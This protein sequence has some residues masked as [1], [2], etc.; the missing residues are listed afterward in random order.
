MKYAKDYGADIVSLDF[1]EYSDTLIFGLSERF[2]A[3]GYSNYVVEHDSTFI[4]IDADYELLKKYFGMT[5]IIPNR[6][7]ADSLCSINYKYYPHKSST[8][9]RAYF[10]RYK[11]MGN[12]FQLLDAD[13]MP[14]EW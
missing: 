10:E 5:D 11:L 3:E 8:N 4:I 6:S 2:Y 14:A 13:F 12:S 9:P 7:A 1:M